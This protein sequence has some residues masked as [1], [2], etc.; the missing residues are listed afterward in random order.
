MKIAVPPRIAAEAEEEET[1]NGGDERQQ[2]LENGELAFSRDIE[3]E[4]E[5][6]E[7]EKEEENSENN[8]NRRSNLHV[9][10][11]VQQQ[12]DHRLFERKNNCCDFCQFFVQETAWPQTKTTGQGR[13][14]I[15]FQ[16]GGKHHRIH[17]ADDWSMPGRSSRTIGSS[18][19][20]PSLTNKSACC[21]PI[22]AFKCPLH[23]PIVIQMPPAT[24]HAQ[25][26]HFFFARLYS[27]N[28]FIQ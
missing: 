19:P 23:F 11:F 3:E 10:S 27:P 28:F 16:E 21:R 15:V 17:A 26:I 8:N 12:N 22:S 5:E 14:R 18:A 9:G 20:Q 13:C 4:K 1:G 24:F 2:K 7:F 6:E 25:S